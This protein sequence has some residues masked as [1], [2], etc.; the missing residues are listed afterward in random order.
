MGIGGGPPSSIVPAAPPSQI[1]QMS[2]LRQ[3]QRARFLDAVREMQRV[4]EKTSWEAIKYLT[5][6]NGTGAIALLGFMG[7][8]QDVRHSTWAW[9][10]LFFYFLGITAVGLL[11]AL[12][13][14]KGWAAL[15]G[16]AEN[17]A[18]WQRGEINYEKVV[19]ELAAHGSIAESLYF[20][21]GAFLCFVVGTLVTVM[22]H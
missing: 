19:A 7:N 6:T 9:T 15:K 5:L 14:H 10:A 20:A 16:L 3:E 22:G 13:F 4:T 1:G 11:I 12:S 2:T 8:S 17:G 21:Y 18:A